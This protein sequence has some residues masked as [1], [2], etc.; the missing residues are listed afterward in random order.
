MT[1]VFT[2]MGHKGPDESETG[3]NY[4]NGFTKISDWKSECMA[5]IYKDETLLKMLRYSI[6]DWDKAPK[7]TDQDK[8]EIMDT[9]VYP[10]GHIDKIAQKQR[11]YIGLDLSNWKLFEGFRRFS[12]KYISGI[13]YFHVLVDINILRTNEGVRS[14]LIIGRL[15]SIFDETEFAGLG[16]L[17]FETCFE[18]KVDNASHVGYSLGFRITELKN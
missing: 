6:P 13:L 15:M 3:V 9:C 16:E 1:E 5:R 14:D 7:L 17:K 12:Y 11:S 18:R 8:D 10:M 2:M 4:N